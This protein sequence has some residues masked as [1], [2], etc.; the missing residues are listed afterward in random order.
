LSGLVVVGKRELP[1]TIDSVSGA[2]EDCLA[3]QVGDEDAGFG[4][5]RFKTVVTELRHGEECAIVE[6][7]E[8]KD[9][10]MAGG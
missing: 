1:E 8:G 5:P 10:G 4:K 7:G 9:M 2:G 3:V 6:I